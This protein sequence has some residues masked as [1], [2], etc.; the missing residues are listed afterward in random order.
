MPAIK[1]E[2]FDPSDFNRLI[3]WVQNE[4]ELL[5]FA[6][7]IFQFPLDQKQLTG[8]INRNDLDAF[9]VVDIDS[10]EV[11]GH[12]ELNYSQE[13]PRICRV[14]IGN[15]SYRGKGYGQAII[16]ALSAYA[17]KN[18]LV[19]E[20]T[21]NVFAWNTAAVKCYEKCGFMKKS[22]TEDA[23]RMVKYRS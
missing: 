18:P 7:P 15:S 6:G 5:Q 12:C 22:Q 14:I 17:F 1:L 9:K 4:N 10:Q 2:K 20:I 11:I 13:S 19:N 21:L 23:M 16:E 3:S 8:Y